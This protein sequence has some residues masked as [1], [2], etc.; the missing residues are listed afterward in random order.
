MLLMKISIISV[1][2][3]TIV[4]IVVPVTLALF[5]PPSLEG[6]KKICIKYLVV[7]SVCL[8]AIQIT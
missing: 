3:F 4:L 2:E 7:L 1:Y 5:Q 6:L 8:C